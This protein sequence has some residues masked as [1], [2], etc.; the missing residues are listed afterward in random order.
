MTHRQATLSEGVTL[1]FATI[2]TPVRP[3][4][5]FLPHACLTPASVRRYLSSR[6]T[7]RNVS[8]TID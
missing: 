8:I 1:E 2:P 5:R 6:S 4:R 3:Q 7:R